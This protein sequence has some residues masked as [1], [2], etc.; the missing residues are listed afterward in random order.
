MLKEVCQ[1]CEEK[2]I[3]PH[4]PGYSPQDK[5]GKLRREVIKEA[6]SKSQI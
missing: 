2:T 4:P 5:F 1:Y 3:Y 6:E